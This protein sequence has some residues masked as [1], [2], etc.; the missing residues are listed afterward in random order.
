MTGRLRTSREGVEL[1]KSFEGFREEPARLPDGRW[2]IGYGHVRSAREGVTITE[3]DAEDLLRFDLK[4]IEDAVND[5]VFAPLSQNQ[6]DAL[7]SLTFNISP[8]Q[9]KDSDVLRNLNAGDF[10]SAA[11]EFDNWRKA[12]IN[13]RV[14][15]VDALVRRR[16][17]EKAMFLETPDGRPAA[18]TPVV[19]PQHDAQRLSREGV[20]QPVP[21]QPTASAPAESAVD[22]AAAVDRMVRS[23]AAARETP[24]PAATGPATPLE[25]SRLVAERIAR[26]LDRAETG[27]PPAAEQAPAPPAAEID[28][29]AEI[30]AIPPRSPGPR[31][32]IDD[33]EIR[34][35][36]ADPATGTAADGRPLAIRLA[37]WFGLVF[38]SAIGF[39]VAAA[40]SFGV[41]ALPAAPAL[42]A[43]SGLSL[44]MGAYFIATR[45]RA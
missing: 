33:T 6:F 45:R 16:A 8:G 30:A 20:V 14:I 26:I 32:F 38:L 23:Q 28:S 24:A 35:P 7:V 22:V 36:D 25:A 43:V 44:V 1:I 11:A 17:M 37:P 31:I 39:A 42:M 19:T 29:L 27:A 5:L 4:P 40:G 13:G 3:H 2:T 9:F 21:V 41:G 12:R 34:Y 15:V 10:L 18:P